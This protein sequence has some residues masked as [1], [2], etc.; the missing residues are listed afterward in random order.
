MRLRRFGALEWYAGA[1]GSFL[2]LPALALPAGGVFLQPLDLITCTCCLLAVWCVLKIDRSILIVLL[3]TNLS[4]VFATLNN[5][6]L[7]V[8]AYYFFF[9]NIF[10][11]LIAAALSVPSGQRAFISLFMVGGYVSH[12][13]AFLQFV[14]GAENLDLRNNLNFSLPPQYGRAFA[15]FPEVS[16]FAAMSIP[17]IIILMT[18]AVAFNGRVVIRALPFL[19]LILAL[20]NI[21]VTRSTSV[22][23]IFP[24]V[25][26]Y[27]FAEGRRLTADTLL[28][29]G[30]IL[31]GIGLAVLIFVLTFYADRMGADA[32]AGRSAE[33]RFASVIAAAK[34]FLEG[35]VMGVGIG[36]NSQVAH[37]Y[38]LVVRELGLVV[39]LNAVGV[40]SFLI[41]R[42][43]EEGILG[44]LQIL[45]SLYF[46]VQVLRPGFPAP[47]NLKVLL[48]SFFLSAVLVAGYRG[49]YEYWLMLIVPVS[50][51]SAARQAPA[52]AATNLEI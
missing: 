48:L 51:W 35:N 34:F 7:P 10:S 47:R 2:W 28:K 27:A 42:I 17:F 32:S 8:A 14:A 38:L 19:M 13:L 15:L 22:L 18:R 25:A 6:A 12:L 31:L 44:L 20:F 16:L 4:W 37:L 43:F 24:V 45:L 50:L 5:G 30:V 40:N 23:I 3:A 21:A 33:I 11:V 46:L 52:T 29:L 39:D 1:T 41:S 36:N 26:L 9:V 49:L